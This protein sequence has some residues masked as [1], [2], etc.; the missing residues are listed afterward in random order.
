VILAALY[1][2]YIYNTADRTLPEVR[3]PEPLPKVSIHNGYTQFDS[4]ILKLNRS[5]LW[6][7]HLK[8]DAS[9]RGLAFGQLCKELMYKQEKAFVDQ[10]VRLVPSAGY[11]SFLKY[12]TIIYN[13]NIGKNI[14]EEYRKEIYATSLAC[15]KEFDYIGKAYDRQ[16]NYHAAHDLGHAMQEYMLVGCSSFGVWG[17]LT[18][19]S[20]LLIGRNFDF[21]VGE[22]FAE[23]KIV[24]FCY[25]DKG[26]KF[27]AIGWAGMVGVLSGMNEKGLTVTLNAAK[28]SPP[29]SSKT[30]IS[31][32]AREIL[33][34]SSNI[35]E[36]YN[37]AKRLDAF[38]SESI[39][40]GSSMDGVAAIIEKTP[41]ST[42]L[43]R[44]DGDMIISTNHFQSSEFCSNKENE[45]IIKSLEGGHSIYR[46]DRIKE[47]IAAKT[48]LTPLKA[49][50]IL[51][52]P[53]GKSNKSIGWTNEK[54]INQYISHHAVIFDPQKRMMWVSSDPWQL[55]EMVA[56]NLDS[57]FNKKS[58]NTNSN[59]ESMTIAGDSSI[60]NGSYSNVLKFKKLVSKFNTAI[61]KKIRLQENAADLLLKINPDYY[62]SYQLLG[63]YYESA[64][65]Y[66]KAID[67]YTKSL[68]REVSSNEA[69]KEIIEKLNKL[70][71][72]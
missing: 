55:G 27:A 39:L 51:R 68:K 38:V 30:P 2:V 61:K 70:E 24:T 18:Q 11:L 15:S 35:E 48:P 23:N 43:Y 7:L 59:M 57:V 72:L 67:M 56:Y 25:P 44:V 46:F 1:I 17:G 52:N 31:I 40:I 13:R 9:E 28:S 20:S 58:F 21:Y 19:D 3:I 50:Q 66:D 14:P 22:E 37:I 8:G 33:Q 16:L 49:A 32:I 41:K 71:K 69:R 10:I 42:I 60:V 45:K 5:G 6:E 34:Y 65:M 53:Y 29:V 4:S 64:E 36:A 47:L 63:E 26:Y 12:V 62:Y 54:S